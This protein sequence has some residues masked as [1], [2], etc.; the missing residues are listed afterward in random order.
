MG[1]SCQP[2]LKQINMNEIEQYNWVYDAAPAAASALP[3]F[4]PIFLIVGIFYFIVIRPQQKEMQAHQEL[5][6]G[7]LKGD[8]VVTATGLHGKIAEVREAEVVL[9]VADKV[10]VTFDKT[11]IKRKGS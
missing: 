1:S 5:L 8:K 4:L 6:A 3:G 9:E 7:L 10:R 2:E 11:A